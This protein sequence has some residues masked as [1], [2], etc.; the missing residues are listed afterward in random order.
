MCARWRSRDTTTRTVGTSKSTRASLACSRER[1]RPKRFPQC[2]AGPNKAH[3]PGSCG[4]QPSA[5]AEVV[6]TGPGLFGSDLAPSIRC[7]LSQTVA[8]ATGRR[9][10]HFRQF[11]HDGARNGLTI[12]NPAK[13]FSLS[14]TTTHS[15]ASAMAAM[16]MSRALLGRPF[17]VPSAISRPQISPA[18]SSNVSTR[19]ANNASGPSGPE[20]QSCNACRFFPAGFSSTSRWT[21]AT[22]ER[23]PRRAAPG[24]RSAARALPPPRTIPA[25]GRQ[26]PINASGWAFGV[27]KPWN[28]GANSCQARPHGG[29]AGP[30]QFP[31]TLS[32]I[33][34][35]DN[36]RTTPSEVT[37]PPRARFST[38]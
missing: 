38:M 32:L 19:P 10:P 27:A 8:S 36:F 17:A 6:E 33:V 21:S 20:N 30:R 12:F 28:H 31:P 23:S 18:F 29:H 34:V 15:L 25:C 3:P 35:F 9:L 4:A 5:C 26:W 14:V 2:Y 7:R 24:N 37:K 16:I 11:G 13:S 22:V 1:S